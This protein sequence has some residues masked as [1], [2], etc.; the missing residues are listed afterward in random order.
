MKGDLNSANN[1]I[2][3]IRGKKFF[4]IMALYAIAGILA[5]LIFIKL[6]KKVFFF[7]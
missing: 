6:F 4:R 5:L 7:L 2:K 1:S 3:A